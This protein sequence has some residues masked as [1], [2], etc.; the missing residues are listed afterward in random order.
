MNR[1]DQTESAVRRELRKR[2][3]LA[4]AVS[5]ALICQLDA[6]PEMDE[7]LDVIKTHPAERAFVVS[8]FLDSFGEESEFWKSPVSLVMYCMAHLR[9]AEIKQFIEEGKR[10]DI[11]KHGVI[12]ENVWWVMLESFEDG[13]LDRNFRDFT[14]PTEQTK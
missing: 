12:T 1:P 13:W 2:F 7:L 8:L 14:L 6:Q 11:L 3:R 4:A 10:D 5:L 9:W